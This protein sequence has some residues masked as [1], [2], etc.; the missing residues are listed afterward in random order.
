MYLKTILAQ[1]IDELDSSETEK[2]LNSSIS[3]SE[4]NELL[5]Q[6]KKGFK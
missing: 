5:S 3:L 4:N 2:K 1:F 6:L